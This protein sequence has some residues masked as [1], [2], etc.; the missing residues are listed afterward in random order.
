M[1]YCL[2]VDDYRHIADESDSAGSPYM[3][4]GSWCRHIKFLQRGKE[5]LSAKKASFYRSVI[6]DDNEAMLGCCR[7]SWRHVFWR[8][9]AELKRMIKPRSAPR[10]GYDPLSYAQ[11]FDD[12]DYTDAAD[13]RRY[14][15]VIR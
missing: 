2:R 9:R 11:N 7:L 4:R 3:K 13:A 10:L 5:W 8:I 14:S 1:G 15:F 12:G 6:M